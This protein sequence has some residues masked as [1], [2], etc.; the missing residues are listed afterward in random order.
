VAG[1]DSDAMVLA[2]GGTG[3]AGLNI[4]GTAMVSGTTYNNTPGGAASVT[5][6]LPLGDATAG[7][8]GGTIT[9]GTKSSGAGGAGGGSGGGTG[10][11]AVTSAGNGKNGTAPGGA[12]SGGLQVTS[13]SNGTGGNGAAGAVWLTYTAAGSGPTITETGTTY[14]FYT[15]YGSA[16]AP[17]TISVSGTNLTAGILVSANSGFEVSTSSN[18]GFSSSVTLPETSGTVGNTTVYIRLAAA[19][20]AGSYASGN[21]SLTSAGATTVNVAIPAS[22]VIAPFTPGNVIVQQADNSS[23]QNTTI[24]MLELNAT[25]SATQSTPVQSIPLPNS[26][27]NSSPT[28]TQALRIN[29]SGG[30]TGYLADTYDQTLLAIVAANC[31]S[32]GDFTQT[33]A[34]DIDNRAVVTLGGSGNLVFQTYYTGNGGVPAT[35]N[36]AR[37]ATSLDDINWFVADKGGIY[38]TGTAAPATTPLSTTNMLNVRSFGD[39]VY[40]FS[41]TAPGVTLITSTGSQIGTLNTLPGSLSVS[42]YADFY[43]ISS[44]VN[45]AAFDVCYACEETAT[46]VGAIAKFSLV[47][48]SWVSNGTYTTNFGGRSMCAIG[49]GTGATLFLAGG[50][51]GS[52]GVSIVRAT[53]N[54]PWGQPIAVT[55]ASNV[56]IYTFPGGST[57]PTP[58]GISFAPL[59]AP[60]PDLTIGVAAPSTVPTNFDYTVSLGNSGAA[61]AS[62]ITA[63]FTLPTGLTYVSGTDN[64]GDG[65]S[66]SN[67]SGTVTISGGTL[68]ANVTDTIT[69]AVTGVAG[70]TYTV[71]SGTAATVVGDG[72]AVINTSAITATPIAESN[73]T[74]NG[75]DVAIT[76]NVTTQP[77]LGVSVSGPSTAQADSNFNYTLTVTNAGEPTGS[78]SASAT[79]TLPAGVTYVSGS[80]SGSAGFTPSYNSMTGVVTFSGGTLG[81]YANET[82][83]VTVNAATS[84]YRMYNVNLPAGAA[85]V[86]PGSIA[87]TNTVTTSITLP[88]GPDLVVTSIPGGPFQAGDTADTFT[89]YV[90]NDGTAAETDPVTLTDTLPAGFTFVSAAG[91]GWSVMV[92]GQVITATYSSSIAPGAGSSP[93]VI[94]VSVASNASGTLS[95]NLSVTSTDDAF[96][97]NNSD[98]N[99]IPVAPPATYTIAGSLIVTRGHYEG[100]ASTVTVGEILPNGSAATVSGSYPYVWGDESPDVSFGVTAPIYMDVVST[101]SSLLYS[102]SVTTTTNLTALIASELGENVTTSFSSKSELGVN[103]TPDG[104][105]VTFLGYLAP[106]NTL[107]VSN[108]NTPYHIDPTN[109]IAANGTYQHVIVQMDYLGDLEVTPIDA[110]SGDNARNVIL[111]SATD[112]NDYYYTV[113]SAGNSGTG[114]SG[115]TMGM[116]AQCTGVQMIEPGAGGLTIAVGFPWGTYSSSTGYQLGYDGLST[117]KSGKDMNLRGLTLDTFNNTLY[118]AKGSGGNGPDTIYQ[119]GSGGLPTAANANTQVY[120]IPSGLP[121][122]GSTGYYPFGMWF[123]SPSILY[124]A[125]EGEAPAPPTFDSGAGTYDQAIPANNPNAG[126]QKWVNSAPDGSGT[127]T[128]VYVLQNGLNLGQPYAYTIHNYP[129]G[130]NPVTGVPWQPANNGLRNFAAQNNGDGTVTIYAITATISGETD[131]G[132]DP[133]QLVSITDSLSGT[134]PSL[135]S[136]EPFNVLEVADGFDALRGVAIAQAA[137]VNNTTYAANVTAGNANLIGNVNPGGTDT[138]VYIQYGTTTA[139]GLE[140]AL[141]NLGSGSNPAGFNFLLSGL[142]ASTTYDYRIV[143]VTSSGTTYYTNQTFTTGPVGVP[144]TQPW[145]LLVIPGLLAGLGAWALRRKRLA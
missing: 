9:G 8:N 92:S 139:Y 28:I 34:A 103:P 134:N 6:D 116:L 51:G 119:I 46:N 81:E 4:S 78:G 36:Q 26:N 136:S 63:Q 50:N 118:A 39:Q 23:I 127:W 113:G 32:N 93:L 111:A 86:T 145:T 70:N 38:V 73:T 33:T 112:G 131:F 108:S 22:V 114:V 53:D 124:V 96:P 31:L 15:A 128:M 25:T 129:T 71:D 1:N 49:S 59:V 48:G 95:N 82:L 91:T 140:T 30:T 18:S 58:K 83:T 132:A 102:S 133:N 101:T 66:V 35:G 37:A 135:A 90:S 14:L 61:N 27:I 89:I 54:A 68:N 2:V 97:E 29:G 94:T 76:T 12:G 11:A 47:N 98:S 41:A 20:T 10:G 122:S 75:S 105:G 87:S 5:G 45:G 19:D 117:D 57:G 74:N 120:T 24:T 115:T 79:F 99:T 137:P 121:T 85:V 55:S 65:F 106:V 52:S 143:T 42:S 142:Q 109:L 88:G 43:M 62:G 56:N 80:D 123:A 44:G 72:A 3:A 107:D 84:T 67:N 69:I 13:A 104:S 60:L 17:T 16:S 64:G 125:D 126:L 110:Y 138:K 141:Y 77:I 21:I 100:T 7:G 130:T 144:A 40:G